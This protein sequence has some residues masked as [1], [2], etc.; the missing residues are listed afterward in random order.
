M[1]RSSSFATFIAQLAALLLMVVLGVA[2]AVWFSTLDSVGR[3]AALR[4][5]NALSILLFAQPGIFMTVSI[6]THRPIGLLGTPRP[7]SRQR[8]MS[9]AVCF[10]VGVIAIPA[11]AGWLIGDLTDTVFGS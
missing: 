9:A 4:S 8:L 7:S 6:L 2:A 1:T 5:L 3:E 11:G 10:A